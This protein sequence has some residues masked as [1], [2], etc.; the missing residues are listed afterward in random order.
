M[1]NKLLEAYKDRIA[2][3]NKVY[4]SKHNG[5]A[6]SESKQVLV[7]TLLNNVNKRMNEAFAG[8]LA[9]QRAGMGEYKKFCLALTTVAIPNL[10]AEDLVI[11]H[12]MTSIHGY[13]A[14]VKYSYGTSK[15]ET[16]QKDAMRDVF[17]MRNADVNYTGDKVVETLTSGQTKVAWTP[18]VANSAKFLDASGN[19]LT[20]GSVAA[21]GT[22]TLPT[23]GTAAKVAY[24]YDNVVIPQNEIP[25]LYAEMDGIELHAKAR[26]IGIMYS[27]MAAYEAKQDYGFDLP[28]QLSAQAVA[29]L[30]YEIDSEIIDLLYNT[31]FADSASVVEFN[32]HLPTGVGIKDHYVGF[33]EKVEEGRQVIFNRTQKCTP[34]YLVCGTGVKTVLTMI[35][36]FKSS[37]S[38][39][40]A[41]PYFAGTLND[42]KVYVSPRL[43]ANEFFL[44]VNSADMATSVAVFAPYMAIIPTSLLDFA[45]GA[46]TQG[47][48][49][50]YDL[51]VLNADLAIGG[52]VVDTTVEGATAVVRG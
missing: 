16:A 5:A 37:G 3:S 4:A 18:V 46:T 35:D 14:Y 17:R 29:E 33:L 38:G 31:A 11:V 26:R 41:G 51:K 13:V 25:T 44:G 43:P 22:I 42:L 21:D 34:N 45:D 28:E 39:K 24:I 30:S 10:I 27:Q 7:A 9:T 20:G 19:V 50:M 52:R 2:V 23:E 32:K 6:L 48:S 8:S 1:A 49:T 36:A 40:M 47:F 15:G 12:P